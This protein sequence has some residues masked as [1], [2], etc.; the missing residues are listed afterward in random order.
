MPAP[1]CSSMPIPEVSN[2]QQ[3]MDWVQALTIF[4]LWM[5]APMDSPLAFARNGAHCKSRDY[6]RS[7]GKRYASI[8]R[9]RIKSLLGSPI[10]SRDDSTLGVILVGLL[11]DHRF[12]AREVR[13]LDALASQVPRS[14][15]QWT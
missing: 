12:T 14:W 5:P 9:T 13:K 4:S 7:T 3:F 1:F 10:V 15:K 8:R 2:R 6:R 11:V